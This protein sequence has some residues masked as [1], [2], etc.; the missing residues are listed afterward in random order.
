[1]ITGIVLAAGSSSRLG[2]PKQLLEL[3]GKPVLQHVV[4]AAEAGGVDETLVVIGH[5]AKD[6][7]ATVRLP[8]SARF[9]LN[10]DHAG[11]QS[12]S[13]RAG[14]QAVGAGSLAAVV[15]LGDQPEVRPQAIAAVIEA[16][17]LG[18]GELLQASY[19]GRPGHP[20]MFDRVVWPEVLF[21]TGDKGARSVLAGQRERVRHIEVGGNPPHDIDTE[22][23]YALL[24][25]RFPSL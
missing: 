17:Q 14:L 8:E 10:H 12:T 11:G 19:G 5:A 21:A 9:V 24:R 3:G 13:L 4:D 16:W 1:V 22:E 25:A 18:E 2:R 15:L 23:D 6:V 7:A 20:V